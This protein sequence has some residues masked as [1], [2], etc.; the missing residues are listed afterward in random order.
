MAGGGKGGS[1][2]QI[3]GY[4]YFMANHFG[5]GRGPQNELTEIRIGD[6]PAWAGSMS[7]IGTSDIN[8]PSL[9]G[10]DQKEGGIQ[11]TFYYLPGAADQTV[12]D[13][14][15][16]NIEGGFPVPAWRGVT[17]VFY[18][19]QISSNNPYPKT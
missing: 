17:S 16:D 1:A 15:K 9:F 8:Q 2:S 4:K 11:G 7:S 19:G 14:V 10:G 12:P 13:V 5:L 18:Y 6:I 3:T